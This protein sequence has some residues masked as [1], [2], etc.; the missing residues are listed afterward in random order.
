ML[1]LS[2]MSIKRKVAHL[3]IQRKKAF[4]GI[5][6]WGQRVKMFGE[7]SVL[8]I[9]HSDAEMEAVTNM[10]RQEIYPY[11]R[12]SLKGNEKLILDFGCGPGRFTLDLACMISGKA[13]GIDPVG[14]LLEMAPKHENVEYKIMKEGMIPLPDAYVDIIWVCLVL[15]CI[16]KTALKRTIDDIKRVLKRDGLLFLIENTSNKESVEHYAFRQFCDYKE[17]FSF[18]TLRHL[19]DYFDLGERIS[20]MAGRSI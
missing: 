10:Q 5:E 3:L 4:N 15:G 7:R 1:N 13:I 16:R 12:K 20:I 17:M 14:S 2:L 19:H 11:F 18:I 9:S 6:Y 8:N